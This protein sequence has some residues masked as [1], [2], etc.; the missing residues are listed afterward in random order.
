MIETKEQ[1]QNSSVS[2]DKLIKRGKYKNKNLKDEFKK[3]I[4]Y[5]LKKEENK[6]WKF[7][8]S[9]DNNSNTTAY[10]YCSDTYCKGRALIK[11]ILDGKIEHK[12]NW[13]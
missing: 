9:S 13:M 3:N 6:I 5:K 7:S 10:Y 4:Q 1:K 2:N 8:L 12:K 11:Y